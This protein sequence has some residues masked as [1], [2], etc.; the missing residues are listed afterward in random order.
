MVG[1]GGKSDDILWDDIALDL[2]SA[3]EWVH[4][5]PNVQKIVFIA[6]SGGGPLMSYYQTVVGNGVGVCQDANKFAPCNDARRGMI[7]ANG[8]GL[9]ESHVGYAT[10]GGLL[11]N[12]PSERLSA[13][14][15][16]QRTERGVHGRFPGSF[17]RR[18]DGTRAAQRRVGTAAWGR[19]SGG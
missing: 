5:Q 3:V 12:D 16:I 17:V 6:Y 19:D 10:T 7:P 2:K 11:T 4:Q 1:G 14:K 13:R 9:L 15:W 8:M 18:P